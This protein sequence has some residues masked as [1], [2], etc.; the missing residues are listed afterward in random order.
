MYEEPASVDYKFR[1]KLR[2]VL[3]PDLIASLLREMGDV[4]YYNADISPPNGFQDF[5]SKCGF[6]DNMFPT[7]YDVWEQVVTPTIDT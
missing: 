3:A 4:C 1:C 7:M 5:H 6:W 2:Q